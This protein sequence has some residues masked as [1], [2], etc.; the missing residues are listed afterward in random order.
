MIISQIKGGLGN[1]MFQYAAGRVLAEKHGVELCLDTSPFKNRDFHTGFE[2]DRLFGIKN[3]IASG[4]EIKDLIGWRSTRIGTYILSKNFFSFLRGRRYYIEQGLF[5][6]YSFFSLPPDCYI[7]GYWQSEGYF[8]GY[9]DL[10]QNLFSFAPLVSERNKK[11]ADKI[12]N[13]NSVSIHV[14]R[15][16][17]VTYPDTNKRHGT[18]PR[19]YYENAIRYL[20]KFINDPVFFVFSDDMDWAINNIKIDREH[21]FVNHNTGMESYNDMWLMSLCRHHVIANSTFSWWAAWLN[22]SQNKLVVSPKQ[23]FRDPS[24]SS[25]KIIPDQWVRI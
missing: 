8:A 14:R 4:K 3:R 1:Q 21:Y 13:C 6:D 9:E 11:F 5:F 12:I 24:R 17:Y 18:C 2:L 7:T 10:I 22:P 16:D 15:G 19:E 25:S 23:W 20:N